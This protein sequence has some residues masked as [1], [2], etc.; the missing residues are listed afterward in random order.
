MSINLKLSVHV[1][2]RL[3]Q[4]R[5]SSPLLDLRPEAISNEQEENGAT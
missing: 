3:F 5:A 4:L 2:A 1:Y